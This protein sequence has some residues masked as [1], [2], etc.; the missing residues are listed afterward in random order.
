MA[1][2]K[3]KVLSPLTN[4][5]VDGYIVDV[6]ES[7]E[8]WSDLKL[9][10]GSTLRLKQVILQVVR[11]ANEYDPNK[12]PLYLV[13]SSPIMAIGDVPDNLKKKD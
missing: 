7:V 4:K 6:E 9:S 11:I 10:D 2:K 3:T 8:R 12:N 13:Q 5:E 1:E